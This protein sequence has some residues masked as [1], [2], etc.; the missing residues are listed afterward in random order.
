MAEERKYRIRVDG[1]LVDVSKEVYRAYYSI[2]RHTRTLDEKDIRNGKVL[3]SDLDTDE[4]LGEDMIPDMT[5]E[6]VEDSAIYSIL[7]EKLHQYLGMLPPQ[8]MSQ[9]CIRWFCAWGSS[10]EY[11]RSIKTTQM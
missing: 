10:V 5:S 8:D 11:E 7:R 4:L 9:H 3:Y 1:I 6:R 2:E